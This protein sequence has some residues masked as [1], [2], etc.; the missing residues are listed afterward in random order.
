MTAKRT[1][2]V[3]KAMPLPL[4]NS[5]SMTPSSPPCVVRLIPTWIGQPLFSPVIATGLQGGCHES[6]TIPKPRV[7][8]STATRLPLCARNAAIFDGAYVRL[9]GRQ[10]EEILK[11]FIL[12]SHLGDAW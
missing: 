10:V 5:L 6:R 12:L 11:V 3:S 4:E 8:T 7:D 9:P 1:S 2:P